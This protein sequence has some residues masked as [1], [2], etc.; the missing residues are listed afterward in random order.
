[1]AVDA[2]QLS[3][4][5]EPTTAAAPAAPTDPIRFVVLLVVAVEV[6]WIALLVS[7][8]Y[9]LWSLVPW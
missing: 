4:Q 9:A 7:A 5:A 8:V 2:G 6:G 1:M 3:L